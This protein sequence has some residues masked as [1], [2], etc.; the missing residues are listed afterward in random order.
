MHWP[1]YFLD[2]NIIENLWE[3][4][5]RKIHRKSY[6]GQTLIQAVQEM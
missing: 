2:L 5:K 6:T 4:M 3:I 1:P